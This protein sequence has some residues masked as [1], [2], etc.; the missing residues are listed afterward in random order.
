M[1]GEGFNKSPR[2]SPYEIYLFSKASYQLG[3]KNIK[4]T[5][6]EP[7]ARADLLEIVRLI[8]SISDEIDLSMTTNGFT[9]NSLAYKLKEGGLNR[10]NISLHSL[11]EEVFERITGVK[12][13]LKRVLEGINA[14][15]EA[16]LRPIKINLVVL[17]GI[18]DNEVWNII[19]FCSKIGSN[20]HI[21]E[22][23]PVGLGAREFLKYHDNLN[24][25]EAKLKEMAVKSYFR[26]KHAR[27]VYQLPS[28]I[29]VEIVKPYA[30]PMFC[31]SCNRIRLTAEGKIKTCLYREDK[32]VNVIDIL[33]SGM[34]EEE[35]VSELKRRILFANYIREPNFKYREGKL[36]SS[37]K[38]LFSEIIN[39]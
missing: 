10:I 26:D 34:K 22:L 27:P 38:N 17:K 2:L 37:A 16:G 8:R 21:I 3:I 28:G 5:G 31:S 25:I 7:T 35:I 9:M 14:S 20:L 36:I 23:H 18:N 6:G 15:L 13:G 4:L 33:R 12:N 30:N 39:A 19:D 11:R 32:S 29:E 24:V 1:E